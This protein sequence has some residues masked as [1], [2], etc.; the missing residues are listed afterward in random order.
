MCAYKWG[1]N[2][3]HFYYDH[4][5]LSN[6][7]GTTA[8]CMFWFQEHYVL[9]QSCISPGSCSKRQLLQ[10]PYETPSGKT[11]C[12]RWHSEYRLSKC[13]WVFSSH[14]QTKHHLVY[15]K[16]ITANF[17]LS[18]VVI[19][20]CCIKYRQ[21][22]HKCRHWDFFSFSVILF[23]LNSF[24]QL[25]DHYLIWCCL[26]RSHIKLCP[27]PLFLKLTLAGIPELTDFSWLPVG[28]VLRNAGH[29]C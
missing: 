6:A 11:I 18:K 29:F 3:V 10:F 20:I 25:F 12:R 7:K 26:K 19:V 15:G 16:Q 2:W 28:H 17:N 13:G 27:S 1:I 4:N 8:H 23:V 5:T 21:L 24:M 22:K 14:H 9:Q